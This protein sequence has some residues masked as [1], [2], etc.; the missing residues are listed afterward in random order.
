M[1][2]TEI[3]FMTNMQAP[4]SKDDMYLNQAAREWKFFNLHF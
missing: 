1:Y 3:D 2:L 4:V